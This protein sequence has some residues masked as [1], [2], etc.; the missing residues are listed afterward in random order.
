MTL[1]KVITENYSGKK[2]VVNTL[3]DKLKEYASGVE[4]IGCGQKGV[5]GGNLL[6]A[7]GEY[8]IGW[9]L[10]IPGIEGGRVRIVGKEENPSRAFLGTSVA[11]KY[12]EG[13]S[14]HRLNLIR[15]PLAQCGL[16]RIGE[17]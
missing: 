16:E 3:Y 1:R 8:E 10:I 4:R 6:G 7:I 12:L 2:D 17:K 14:T 9:E 5:I 13:T 11:F 15:I